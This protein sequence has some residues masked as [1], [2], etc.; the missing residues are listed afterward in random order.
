MAMTLLQAHTAAADPHGDRAY[1]D[2]KFAT[3]LD[4]TSLSGTVNNL[5]TSRLAV[6]GGTMTGALNAMLSLATDVVRA[7][8]ASGD[9]FDR[10]RRDAAGRQDWGP[11]NSPRD[12]TQYRDGVASLR[13]DGSYTIGAT[14]THLGAL[15]GFFGATPTA[16][17]TVTGSRTTG[18]ALDNLLTA[19]A[20][21][22]LITD[23]TTL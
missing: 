16:Q 6:S 3:Q 15:A 7:S 12:T 17:P 8:L 20:N 21:L 19:L 2:N 1:A 22:G 10:Y 13:T 11:G 14:L 18:A 5:S 23:N 4:L 9:T